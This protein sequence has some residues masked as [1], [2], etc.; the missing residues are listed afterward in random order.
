M[1]GTRDAQDLR[2]K[3][4]NC[5]RTYP[6]LYHAFFSKEASGRIGQ[7]IS[8][9]KLLQVGKKSY[10][11]TPSDFRAKS[12]SRQSE[13]LLSSATNKISKI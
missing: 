11:S 12:L 10:S 4:Q 7:D 5:L 9:Y 8:V 13:N 2:G 1:K 3:L 6:R